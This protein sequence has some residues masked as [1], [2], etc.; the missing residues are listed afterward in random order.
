[1]DSWLKMHAKMAL[2]S[3]QSQ[4]LRHTKREANTTLQQFL[5]QIWMEDYPF[6]YWWYCTCWARYPHTKKR[7]KREEAPDRRNVDLASKK[8]DLRTWIKTAIDAGKP[9]ENMVE[10]DTD[11]VEKPRHRGCNYG[12]D[13][14]Y[15]MIDKTSREVRR[16]RKT[17]NQ[18]PTKW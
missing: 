15:E 18:T 14:S 8:P 6:F 16:T 17:T 3:F 13:K 5:E 1:M 9:T 11:T 12:R 2:K 4:Y 10:E 7:K